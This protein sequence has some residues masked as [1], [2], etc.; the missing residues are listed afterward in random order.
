MKDLSKTHYQGIVLHLGDGRKVKATIPA[1]LTPGE[2]IKITKV[3]CTYP[4]P[5]PP[6]MS[7][8]NME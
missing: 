3:T 4:T 7:W 8:G 6:G 1:V 2:E 5:M